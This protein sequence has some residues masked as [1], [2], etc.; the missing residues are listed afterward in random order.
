[1]G[2]RRLSNRPLPEDKVQAEWHTYVRRLK[3]ALSGSDVEFFKYGYF[4]SSPT[5]SQNRETRGA[6]SLKSA[7]NDRERK[8]RPPDSS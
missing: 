2:D 8:A 7:Y 5:R 3:T 1:V 6:E 4:P